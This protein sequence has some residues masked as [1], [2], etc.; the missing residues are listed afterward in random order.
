MIEV[1]TGY[2]ISNDI[3][4]T[5]V[6]FATD[7][8]ESSLP[9]PTRQWR[10][11]QAKPESPSPELTDE[12]DIELQAGPSSSPKSPTVDKHDHVSDSPRSHKN[13][14][15]PPKFVKKATG[16]YEWEGYSPHQ[17]LKP[18]SIPKQNADVEVKPVASSLCSERFKQ[19]GEPHI[20]CSPHAVSS[21]EDSES[22]DGEYMT[23][24]ASSTCSFRYG[25]DI[26]DSTG[27][28]DP[29]QDDPPSTRL[30]VSL[31]RTSD[32][33][34]AFRNGSLAYGADASI[35]PNRKKSSKRKYKLSHV[36]NPLE[37]STCIPLGVSPPPDLSA[38]SVK[39][40]QEIRINLGGTFT[41]SGIIHQQEVRTSSSNADDAATTMSLSECP[42]LWD[43][44]LDVRPGVPDMYQK[45]AS[46]PSLGSDSI[47]TTSRQH[48]RLQSEK[49]RQYATLYVE[50]SRDPWKWHDNRDFA[51]EI[52]PRL[53]GTSTQESFSAVSRPEGRTPESAKFSSAAH[54][55][56]DQMKHPLFAG[57]PESPDPPQFKRSRSPTSIR[58]TRQQQRRLQPLD[59]A[60]YCEK[61]RRHFR[62]TWHM[63]AHLRDSQLHPNYCKICCI[64]WPTFKARFLVSVIMSRLRRT[65]RLTSACSCSALGRQCTMS[66]A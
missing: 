49:L 1:S 51:R 37:T 46:S 39:R 15:G 41:N 14:Q 38:E 35:S 11:F 12:E 18:K 21:P 27:A 23:D 55:H 64:D 17:G 47:E 19:D 63:Q 60:L 58:K 16:W 13:S 42:P 50:F 48:S 24:E 30:Q 56:A 43:P 26:M 8:L 66:T 54:Q 2:R 59:R 6:E 61:C 25:T 7:H 10:D 22:S 36:Q 33:S 44:D 28:S 34:E 31:P 20:G 62:S 9:V 52:M 4:D 57:R 65:S 45:D 29:F 53:E 32:L 3:H 5:I 40:N